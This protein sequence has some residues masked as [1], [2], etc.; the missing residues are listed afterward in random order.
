MQTT[1]NLGLKLPDLTD[2]VL[3]SDINANMQA[4][5]SVLQDNARK[6]LLQN[7]ATSQT[8]YGVTYTVND[9]G[10]ITC[11]GT[12]TDWATLNI[13]IFTLQA[14]EYVLSGGAVGTT[15]TPY[16]TI[17]D[18]STDQ[19]LIDNGGGKTLLSLSEDT[20]IRVTLATAPNVT[21]TDYTA[22]PMIRK[23]EITD[24][25]Y[26]PYYMSNK[27][28]TEKKGTVY[29]SFEQIG[30]DESAITSIQE[31]GFALP[32]YSVLFVRCSE[33]L[34]NKGLVPCKYGN[35]IVE[36]TINDNFLYFTWKAVGL[37]SPRIYKATYHIDY[38]FDGWIEND[39]VFRTCE[40][41]GLDA[42]T[43]TSFVDIINAMPNYTKAEIC[44]NTAWYDKGLVPTK[45]GLLEIHKATSNSNVHLKWY[46]F[47][48]AA[49]TK[50]IFYTANH[51][52]NDGLS[53]WVKVTTQDDLDAM[54]EDGTFT[55][56]S[57]TSQQLSGTYHK[58]G[59]LVFCYASGTL[60]NAMAA[61]ETMEGLP[62]PIASKLSGV[63]RIE[64]T[65]TYLKN[66]SGIIIQNSDGSFVINGALSASVPTQFFALY[67]TS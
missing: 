66:E 17:R 53:P 10:S 33:T 55:L 56:T 44:Y 31:I 13:N 63:F 30:I 1:E 50:G 46:V 58:V 57:G 59:K 38:G 8:L 49:S 18:Y 41:L 45:Y 37:G 14:G 40:E 43:I 28:L 67:L 34:R 25:T 4:L 6:N 42:T 61:S 20:E 23:A 48:T 52:I 26:E 7:T 5:D 16:M 32:P 51:H 9:D 12:A 3:L 60:K 11:N 36:K 24:D 47:G 21:V 22:Y 39:T 15:S 19:I 35:L 65:T 64:Q 62:F 2:K 27:E 29:T 54:V